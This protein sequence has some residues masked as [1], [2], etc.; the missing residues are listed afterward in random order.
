M[1]VRLFCFVIF[2][3]CVHVAKPAPDVATANAILISDRSTNSAAEPDVSE[4]NNVQVANASP[5]SRE[6]GL[7]RGK[8]DVSSVTPSVV[9]RARLL[10]SEDNPGGFDVRKVIF[11][12]AAFC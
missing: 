7:P 6:S 12:G 11:Q 2:A 1:L 9:E 8:E 4:G 5:I 10:A 3:V